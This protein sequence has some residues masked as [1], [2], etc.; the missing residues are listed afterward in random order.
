M[1]C[2]VY[3]IVLCTST[4]YKLNVAVD[5]FS[6][7]PQLQKQLR[8]VWFCCLEQE[9]DN[10]DLDICLNCCFMN[11]MV[12]PQAMLK[13]NCCILLWFLTLYL[14]YGIFAPCDT[15]SYKALC[16]ILSMSED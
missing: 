1:L 4:Y 10:S 6:N 15:D 16:H 12:G 8:E 5:S 13:I 9:S 11:H 14:S 2:S 7:F 3:S